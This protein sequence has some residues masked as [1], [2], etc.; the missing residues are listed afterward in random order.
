MERSYL[1]V[2]VYFTWVYGLTSIERALVAVLPK[3]SV[4]RTVKW[5]ST[6][7]VGVP[8]ITPVVG[9][10]VNPGGNVPTDIDQV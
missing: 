9:L 10:R 2:S 1:S 7:I 3:I 6:V 8:D 5:E 4:T